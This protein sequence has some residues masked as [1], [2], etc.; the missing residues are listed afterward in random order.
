MAATSRH[1]TAA[2]LQIRRKLKIFL[3][4]DLL[5]LSDVCDYLLS[6]PAEMLVGWRYCWW[7]FGHGK[8]RRSSIS[9]EGVS[10]VDS[11]WLQLQLLSSRIQPEGKVLLSS[12]AR[13]WAD[14][15]R[16]EAGYWGCYD[17]WDSLHEVFQR[18]SLAQPLS[19]RGWPGDNLPESAD[20]T[21]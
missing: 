17:F 5:G 10:I 3:L 18:D 9:T 21:E 6:A 11:D 12:W 2:V 1:E 4:A 20:P 13:L 19:F 15:P 14:A 8:L 7:R 16:V